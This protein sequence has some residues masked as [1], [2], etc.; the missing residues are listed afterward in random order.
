MLATAL[1]RTL[2]LAN[3]ILINTSTAAVVDTFATLSTDFNDS[4]SIDS[5]GNIYVSNAGPFAN[6]RGTGTTVFKISPEGVISNY[7]H[8]EQPT[9]SSIDAADNLYVRGILSSG[10]PGTY[11]ITPDG[12]LSE[13]STSPG[14]LDWNSQGEAFAVSYSERSIFKVDNQGNF[15]TFASPPLIN[16]PVSIVFD[17]NDK[18]YVGNFNDGRIILVN[19]NGTSESV[20]IVPGGM[21]YMTYMAGKFYATGFNSNRIY[22]VSKSGEVVIVAGS[23]SVGQTDGEGTTASFSK[24]NGIAG[25]PDGRTLL[26]SQYGA[27]ARNIRSVR[28]DADQVV[29]QIANNDDFSVDEDT[30]EAFNPLENDDGF[31]ATID[32]TSLVVVQQPGNGSVQVD[33]QTG[34]ITYTSN[35]NYYGT[36]TLTYQVNDNMGAVS[37]E[38]TITIN[39]APIAD[40]P[41]VENDTVTTTKNKAAKIAVLENDSDPDNSTLSYGDITLVSMPANGTVKID[42]DSILYTP[43]ADFTGQDTFDYSISNVS[44]NV[45]KNASVA[46]TIND[47]TPTAPTP[48]EPTQPATSQDSGG[49][50]SVSLLMYL[51]LLMLGYRKLA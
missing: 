12:T 14:S 13:F 40:A 1:K 2:I 20:G 44:G 48:V 43:T 34:A 37:N 6:G 7:Q 50:G 51:S 33:S 46:I 30:S 28:I 38:A 42:T 11:R 49:G 41:I 36:D 17:E 10:N 15:S 45:S 21:G 5:T 27:G 19:Q 25:M 24:P 26:V 32:T 8:I 4:I 18:M 29:V 3:I 9:G 31:G 39:I 22:S 47:D 35:L 23:G 16:G